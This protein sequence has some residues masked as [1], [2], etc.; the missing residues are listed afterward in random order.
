[1]QIVVLGT[2]TDAILLA[3]RLCKQHD[4]VL[5]DENAK[6]KAAY[7]KLDVVA[8][9]GVVIDVAV[10]DEA[11]VAG[12]DVVCALSSVENLNLVAAQICKKKYGVKKVITCIYDTDDYGIYEDAGVYP[13]SATDLTVDAFIQHIMDDKSLTTGQLGVAQASLFGNNYKFKLFRIDKNLAGTK[14]KKIVD[15]EGGVILGIIRDG[16]LNQYNPEYKVQ[17]FDKVLIAEMF[18]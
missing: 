15:T 10:L 4:V 9:D 8:I 16:V 11:N 17:E 1:M 6:E 5:V 12:A 7:N 13:I 2:S 14:I 18:E 3:S